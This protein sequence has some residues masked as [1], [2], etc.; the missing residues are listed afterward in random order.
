MKLSI[1]TTLYRSAAYIRPFCERT[2]AAAR[3]ITPDYEIILVNDGSPDDSLAIAV[4]LQRA[5]PAH[6]TVVDLSRN[7][8]HHKAAMTGLMHAGGDLVFQIDS[9]LE[10]EPELLTLFHARMEESGADVVFGVQ[11]RRKGGWFERASGRLFYLVFNLLS[12]HRVP[13][14]LLMARLMTRQY[15]ANLVA[16]RE[17]EL[18]IA[19]LWTLTG[20]TQ[21]PVTVRKH[22]RETTTYSVGKRLALMVRSITAF[23][24]LPLI[25]IAGLGAFVLFLSFCYFVY[26]QYVR[27]FEGAPPTGFT[28]IILSVWFLGGLTIFSLGVIAIY[29]SVIFVETK[30]RPYTIV[31]RVYGGERDAADRP[32]IGTE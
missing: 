7:F 17:S 4:E 5:D 30:N 27:I 25:W 32:S 11:D 14:D 22:S 21:L 9:D 3:A 16:H 12:T 13:P 1:V 31:R 10:E 8:G 23:S 24:N 18:D 6:I 29:L 28:T 15:V 20:F 19:G 2:A 26:I